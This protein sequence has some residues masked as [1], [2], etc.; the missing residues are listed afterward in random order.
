MSRAP[1]RP[2]I[3]G[4]P[5][6]KPFTWFVL[7]GM[8]LS[9]AGMTRALTASSSAQAAALAPRASAGAANISG[10][11]RAV[12]TQASP[13]APG[14]AAPS[15]PQPA[16]TPLP[17]SA[18][19]PVANDVAAATAVAVTASPPV[20]VTST[21]V[22]PS[23]D[24]QPAGLAAAT[25][26]TLPQKTLPTPTPV[27]VVGVNSPAK[28][29]ALLDL[30]NSARIQANLP[31]LTPNEALADIALTRANNLIEN[32]YFDHYS[33][34]GESAFTELAARGISYHLAGENLARNNYIDSQ[35]VEA[36]FDALMAS[37]G[38]RANILEPRFSQVGVAAVLSGHMWIYVTVF[39]D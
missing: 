7:L 25:V 31:A 34:D 26:G 10:T 23:S 38:H 37:P 27:P 18:A 22:E 5:F 33:P 21:P 13:A 32:G 8:C 30:M 19:L 28:S 11:Q 6:R 16:E 12:V 36:A 2:E 35:T 24:E 20:A 17:G 29:S 9:F 39:K 15:S 3:Q 1:R 4:V 14:T